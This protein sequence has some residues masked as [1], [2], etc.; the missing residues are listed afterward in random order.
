[1][2]P[3]DPS[4]GPT[5]S[6]AGGSC[7]SARDPASTQRL[8]SERHGGCSDMVRLVRGE[9]P[10]RGGRVCSSVRSGDLLRPLI[11]FMRTT[12]RNAAALNAIYRSVEPVPMIWA[13][14]SIFGTRQQGGRIFNVTLLALDS[15]G[16]V[17]RQYFVPI[18]FTTLINNNRLDADS[19]IFPKGERVMVYLYPP[20]QEPA[21]IEGADAVFTVDGYDE[22]SST[23]V[24]PGVNVISYRRDRGD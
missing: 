3:V 14:T 20:N 11:W 6:P 2:A 8:D 12:R 15:S 21:I 4:R 16:A 24:N 22:T 13:D 9:R 7:Q 5:H 10:Q 1:M 17:E 18:S 23:M 19:P